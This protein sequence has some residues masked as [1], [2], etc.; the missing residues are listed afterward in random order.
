M[1][2]GNTSLNSGMQN[3][4]M[5]QLLGQ[6]DMDTVELQEINLGLREVGAKCSVN[7]APSTLLEISSLSLS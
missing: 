1:G 4:L 7:M 2:E 6:E 5:Q 3:R